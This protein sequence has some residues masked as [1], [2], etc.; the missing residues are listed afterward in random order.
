MHLELD[1]EKVALQPTRLW[2][3]ILCRG[4]MFT[5][6]PKQS[7]W[8]NRIS[9]LLREFGIASVKAAFLSGRLAWTLVISL[10]DDKEP[11]AIFEARSCWHLQLTLQCWY[12][13]QTAFRAIS[14]THITVI[15]EGTNHILY[16]VAGN[17][18]SS[19]CSKWSTLSSSLC[20][21]LLYIMIQICL[22][23]CWVV[24]YIL[25]IQKLYRSM[26][27]SNSAIPDKVRFEKTGFV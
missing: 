9:I 24:E 23:A 13:F 8:E 21:Y 7:R 2:P 17:R 19:F 22:L 27:M 12:S 16:I 3:L 20:S 25:Y 6:E 5:W 18:N 1:L 4:T 10:L 14:L 15:A 11:S 26:D